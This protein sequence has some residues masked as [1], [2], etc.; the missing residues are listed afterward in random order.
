MGAHTLPGV[1][2][3]F[4][5]MGT[6]INVVAILLG[7][8]LGLV[9]GHRLPER[10][11]AVVTDCLGL[12][13]LLIAADAAFA[14]ADP[15]L[16]QELGRGVPVLVV[17][18]SLLLGGIGGS[19][20]RIE[21]RIEMMGGALQRYVA[22]RFPA[23]DDGHGARERF[24]QGWL[25]TSLLFCVGP[26]AVLGPIRDGL[27]LGIDQLAL[28]SSLDGF[29][30]LA[31]ASTFGI[32]VAFSALTVGVFQGAFTVVG[33]G[34]GA[35]LPD[36]YVAMLTAVG[37]LLLVGVAF[38]LLRVRDLPVGDLLPALVVAPPLMALVAAL[39]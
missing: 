1:E 34:L 25:T 9:V 20:L 14:V 30:S 8:V 11:R 38:R 21:H 17:L 2:A 12:V 26:L 39:T 29:A 10:V 31:F 33:M 22:R 23:S 37:G 6:I 16:A 32:G 7:S 36:A 5:G 27:G 18:G 35:V 3:A 4:P 24:V 13:T 28:K 19:L 15:A